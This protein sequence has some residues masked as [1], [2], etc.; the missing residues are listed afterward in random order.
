MFGY[1][2]ESGSHQA[3]WHAWSSG[4]V[5][6]A[7]HAMLTLAAVAITLR[8]ARSVGAAGPPL[9]I[10][11]PDDLRRHAAGSEDGI[12]LPAAAVVEVPTLALTGLPSIPVRGVVDRI[13][14]LGTTDEL[15]VNRATSGDGPWSASAVEEPPV[16]LAGPTLTYPEWL[17]ALSIEGRVVI[18]T[19][20]DT[21]GRA[22]PAALRLIESSYSGF[23]APARDF[24]LRARF[25]P[26][27]SHGRTVRVLVRVPIAFALNR[28][29]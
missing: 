23:E 22:E 7:A 15:R 28:P 1:L 29:H 8:P 21:L 25:R 4:A 10:S 6:L 12:P 24:V 17:R 18:E 5:A 19:V 16:L 26:G 9:V 27:R 13:P 20:I 14:M 2:I 3:R 11:W